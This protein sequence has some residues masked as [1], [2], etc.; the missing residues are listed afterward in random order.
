VAQ[1]LAETIAEWS[2]EDV[3]LGQVEDALNELRR[4]EERA[5]VRT[6]VLT[7]VVVI[8]DATRAGE[9]LEIVRHLG[10]RHPSR[11]LVVVMQDE[12]DEGIDA[13]A[14]LHAVE[15]EGRAV[16]FEDVVLS[17]RGRARFHLDSVVEPFTLPDLPVAVW[18]PFRLPAVGDPLL[19][20][21]DRIVVDSRFLPE[22]PGLLRR[23][24]VL[25]RRFPV[26]DLSWVR[27][28][29]WRSLLAGLF[30]GCLKFARG[31]YRVEVTGHLAPRALM[32]GWLMS[33]LHLPPT[34]VTL[35]DSEHVTIRLRATADGRD[36]SFA[37]E[38]I[39]DE[40]IIRASVEVAGGVSQQ[41]TL[42]MRDQPRAAV[43]ADAL[44]RMGH[45]QVYERALGAALE[46]V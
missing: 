29:P 41:Q 30:D 7:L 21:A 3:T 31:V 37:V 5:A 20:S 26:A 14:A 12:D 34:A 17:V 36:A 6:T 18:C 42:R 40:K 4:R 45:E 19:A 16:C 46:L 13:H 35:V 33:S 2:A 9:I 23:V 15:R 22:E 24:G 27:L 32:G 38:R 28:T 44:G 11:T 25:T 10:G 43:L 39:G 1:P 8:D